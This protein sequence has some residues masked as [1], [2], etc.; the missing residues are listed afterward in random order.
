MN[1]PILVIGGTR[2]TGRHAVN[3]LCSKG[4]RV[5]VLARNPTMARQQLSADVEVVAGDL[6]RPDTLLRACAGAAHIVL[7]AGVRS[8][9]FARES[10]VR[11]TEY[12]GVVDTLAAARTHGFAGRLAYM[13]SIG[14]T[15]QSLFAWGLNAWKGNTLLW[16][17]R[18]EEVIRS[19]GIDYT[20]VRAA[21]LLNRPP[22]RREVC[23]T[24][25]DRPLGFREVI[26]RADV[27]QALVAA[28][29]DPHASRVTIEVSWCG[30]PRTKTWEELFA[31]L[32]PD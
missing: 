6:T 7:T 20:V 32:Q 14:T 4:Q 16:R 28:L 19:S 8:G 10:V 30:G 13:T 22:D 29:F 1:E 17:R 2:S 23:V 3:V 27:A 21:F 5:R 24:Q 12:Q 31:T 11:A 15:H 26:S 18:A 25:R 9:R